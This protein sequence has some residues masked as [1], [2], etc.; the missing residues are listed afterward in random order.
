MRF[1]VPKA[2]SSIKR[3]LKGNYLLA[4]VLPDFRDK[5]LMEPI[6]KKCSGS[7]GLLIVKP[8]DWCLSFSLHGLELAAL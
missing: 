1:E 5:T 4:K 3:N 6:K 8:K 7:L 2:L